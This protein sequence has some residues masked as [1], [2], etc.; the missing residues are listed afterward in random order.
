M[1]TTMPEQWTYEHCAV[2]WR[3]EQAIG[4]HQ[5]SQRVLKFGPDPTRCFLARTRPIVDRVGSVLG[6]GARWEWEL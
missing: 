4:V 1:T 5:S 6:S 3:A 2:Q